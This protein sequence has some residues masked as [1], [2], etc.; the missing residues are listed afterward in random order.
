[1][2]FLTIAA[3]ASTGTIGS[4]S[5][6]GSSFARFFRQP[7]PGGKIL[8]APL[9]TGLY[10][11]HEWVS[12]H[13]PTASALTKSFVRSLEFNERFYGIPAIR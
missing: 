12:L 5:V 10:V 7:V 13:T 2:I 8:F 4:N 6:I 1:M 3:G 11:R 9:Q